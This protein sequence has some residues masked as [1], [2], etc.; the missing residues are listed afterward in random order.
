MSYNDIELC[1]LAGG[2]SKR[3]GAHKGNLKIGKKDFVEHIIND[4]G[5][6]F[7]AINVID[8]GQQQKKLPQINYYHDKIKLPEKSGLLGLH[9]ALYYTSSEHCFI[10]SCDTPLVN[11]QITDAICQKRKQADIIVPHLDRINPLYGIYRKKSALP[12]AEKILQ[13]NDHWLTGM[14]KTLPTHY[15]K[16]EV[17]TQIDPELKFAKNIN[18]PSDFNKWVG[19]QEK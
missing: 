8:N 18:T 6:M 1:I 3:M 7:A 4:I 13:G 11:R 14:L 5:D 15:I 17:L 10:L 12:L 19:S 16:R 2:K 9:S